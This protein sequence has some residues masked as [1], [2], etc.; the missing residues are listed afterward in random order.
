MKIKTVNNYYT[1]E[2][3]YIVYDENTK[4]G[5]VID[6]GYKC[7]G[8]LKA[9]QDDGV[10]IKYVLI[11]HCHYDHISDIEQLREKRFGKNAYLQWHVKK[12]GEKE[13][14]PIDIEDTRINDK[15]FMFTISPRDINKKAVFNC[16][17]NLEE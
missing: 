15:G 3:T 10:N 2:N 16:E 14:S 4:N 12:F 13:F 1:D 8:I 6:P 7:D 17:L 11:T 9:A 5:L